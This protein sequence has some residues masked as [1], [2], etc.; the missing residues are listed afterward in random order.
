MP[1][2]GKKWEIVK[3]LES[4]GQGKAFVVVK[5]GESE[6]QYFLKVL[7]QESDSTERRKRFYREVSCYE[8]LKH[9][10]IPR[11]ID[12]NKVSYLDKSATPYLVTEYV[13]GEN[14]L[15]FIEKQSSRCLNAHYSF[16]LTFALLDILEY[17]FSQDT[18]HRDIKP[19][20]IIIRN[21]NPAD[22]V[23][24]DFGL[25]FNEGA[26][27]ITGRGQQLGNRF[28][29]L[30]DFSPGSSDKRSHR[31]DLTLCAGILFFALTGIMPR[32]L[33]DENGNAP[34]QGKLGREALSK[35]TDIDFLR[36]M[37]LFDRAFEP[38][39][40]ARWDS[41][42]SF[43]CALAMI[44]IE[45]N[46][47]NNLHTPEALGARIREIMTNHE[48][49]QKKQIQKS[50]DEALA[51]INQVAFNLEKEYLNEG[52][53]YTSGGNTLD[54]SKKQRSGMIGLIKTS[55]LIT[56]YKPS[57]LIE[58]QGDEVVIS[59]DGD[60]IFRDISSTLDEDNK[61]ISD[62]IKELF[63]RGLVAELSK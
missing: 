11:L 16:A 5:R 50:L 20:N 18:V 31:S 35:H 21:G 6:P 32:E 30:A 2:W 3:N 36:L 62:T 33:R 19:D 59:L 41:P 52:I 44:K 61:R 55:D 57:Y 17:T 9:D 7:N 23:L 26:D 42:N 15:K 53:T 22:P 34:H 14:L 13:P 48:E 51:I 4:G 47:M 12:N 37:N 28:L 39:I 63:L 1:E 54:I 10:S 38:K 29:R 24:V 56:G 58:I 45:E 49:T 46:S 8:T 25:A 60:I 43:R 40:H 27:I